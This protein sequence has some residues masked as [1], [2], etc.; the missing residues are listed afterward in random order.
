MELEISDKRENPLLDRTEVH[1]VVHH[2][3]QPSPRREH[4][5][6][7][8]SNELSVKKE[9]VVVDNLRSSF[10]VHDTKGYAKI[11]SKKEVALKVEREYLIKRN[12]LQ[13]QKAKEKKQEPGEEKS[14]EP[15]EAKKKEPVKPKKAKKEESVKPEKAKE[16]DSSESKKASDEK[17]EKPKEE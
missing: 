15:A 2:P 14:G 4:V 13:E 16:K 12:N 10:G 11:Y 9:L 6:E 7:A 1:F 5:R 17:Q 3:N 8:L